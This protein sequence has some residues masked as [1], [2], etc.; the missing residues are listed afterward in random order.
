MDDE[1]FFEKAAEDFMELLAWSQKKPVYRNARD[2]SMGE[3]GVLRCLRTNGAPMS[4]GELGHALDIGSG[5]VA[6]VLNSLEKK[7]LIS[8]SMNLTDRRRI[9]VSL[10]DKGEEMASEKEKEAKNLAMGL[11]RELGREDTEELL[12][13]YRRILDIT[14][15]YLKNLCKENG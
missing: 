14:D 15:A 5:G 3:M 2:L 11:L 12:R 8:R 10:S 13:I 7:E 6:N 1:I 4:A 9:R